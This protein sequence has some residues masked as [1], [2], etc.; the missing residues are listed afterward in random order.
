[1]SI[2]F[3]FILLCRNCVFSLQHWLDLAKAI[4]KQ[5]K[6]VEPL[7]LSFRVKFYP[8]DPSK[9]SL[10]GKYMLFQQLKRDLRHGRLYCSLNE[11]A[12]LGSLI[13]QG[14][15]QNIRPLILI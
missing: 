15:I 3:F 1:M 12:V 6:D 8:A 14:K 11:G 5:V 13:I 7:V 9:L 4:I 2:N 10:N